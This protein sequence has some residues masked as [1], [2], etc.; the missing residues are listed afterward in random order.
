MES[1]NWKDVI[2]IKDKEIN[3]LTKINKDYQSQ[4]LIL[5][6]TLLERERE[7]NELYLNS[8]KEFEGEEKYF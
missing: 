7:L 4:I 3:L 5:K 1:T 6:E 8:D 2:T